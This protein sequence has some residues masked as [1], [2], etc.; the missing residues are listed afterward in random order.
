MP[1]LASDYA[2]PHE[3]ER[4]RRGIAAA[5]EALGSGART[6]LSD[7]S[8]ELTT[9]ENLLSRQQPSERLD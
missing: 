3:V 9:L 8:A 2:L 1:S 5:E 7:E 6:A 4:C